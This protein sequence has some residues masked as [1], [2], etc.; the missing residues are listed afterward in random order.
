MGLER[1]TRDELVAT[2]HRL[3]GR[4]RELEALTDSV[5]TPAEPKHGST[6][7]LAESHRRFEALLGNLP[8]MVY[9][10]L[11]DES[12]T[13]RFVSDGFTALT[14]YQPEDLIDNRVISYKELVHPEDFESVRAA[15]GDAI[16][17]G[18]HFQVEYRILTADGTVKW[19]WE[20]GSVVP[21]TVGDDL[22]LEG[23][24]HRLSHHNP[25]PGW[26]L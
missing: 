15:V 25:L 21:G 14:G 20:Q 22:E 7:R 2:I 16:A 19:V 11:A 5:P 12:W 4:V 1:Q 18:R 13:M 10:C 26:R 23:I 9:L 3:E 24:G 17:R 6:E 8:G